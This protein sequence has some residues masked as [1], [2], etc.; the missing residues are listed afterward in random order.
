MSPKRL[1]VV[2]DH[3]SIRLLLSTALSRADFEVD[4]AADGKEAVE[5][6]SQG[7]PD[8]VLMDLMMPV[9]DGWEATRRIKA[10]PA[11]ASIPVV[12][13]TAGDH[14]GETE[15]LRSAGFSA[16]LPKPFRPA[17]VAQ[18]V[19]LCL[20]ASAAGK[21]WIDLPPPDNPRARRR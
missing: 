18:A 20:D 1:L 16:Y 5:R 7:P 21:D 4:T 12:A 14:R 9:L 15:R 13:V 6:I 11:T 10:N 17:Q 8:L 3:E 2:D 19:T